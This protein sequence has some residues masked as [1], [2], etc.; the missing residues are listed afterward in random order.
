MLPNNDEEDLMPLS[1]EES[2]SGM[3]DY[4]EG[5][6]ADEIGGDDYRGCGIPGCSCIEDELAD[7]Y[8]AEDD[9]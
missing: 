7:W 5:H 8:D 4:D 1:D 2:Y 3:E 9:D 6:A